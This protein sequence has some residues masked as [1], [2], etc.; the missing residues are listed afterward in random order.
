[1]PVTTR[2]RIRAF[3][4]SDYRSARDLWER[5]DGMGLNESDTEAAIASFLDRNPGFSAIATACGFRDLRRF[6][7]SMR[8]SSRSRS[9]MRAFQKKSREPCR[10]SRT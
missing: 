7:L 1:M 4:A 5:T 2:V 3:L 9:I 8:H 6:R 10:C